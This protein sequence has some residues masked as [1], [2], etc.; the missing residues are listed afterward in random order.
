MILRLFIILLLLFRLFV[1][2]LVLFL[3]LLLL[4][5]ILF[6]LFLLLLLLLLL[7]LF[8]LSSFSSTLYF[9]FFSHYSTT[10]N[11]CLYFSI[12][13]N[14]CFTFSNTFFQALKNIEF[15]MQNH[16]LWNH[17]RL[18]IDVSCKK[19]RKCRFH[20]SRVVKT[21][22]LCHLCLLATIH[23]LQRG[24]PRVRHRAIWCVWAGNFYSWRVGV[25]AEGDKTRERSGQWWFVEVFTNAINTAVVR[26]TP[27]KSLCC[28]RC[29][30][31]SRIDKIWCESYAR[32]R[33]AKISCA[34]I[35]LKRKPQSRH[36]WQ[37]YIQQL[38]AK[39]RLQERCVFL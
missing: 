24:K 10:C 31:N 13:F 11:T 27:P 30:Y 28:G 3:F 33:D 35:D 34:K 26:E 5:S 7:L 37:K 29:V 23:D 2:L 18:N 20:I 22:I 4:L 9:S 17:H 19:L 1:L 39:H 15:F 36:I 14:N 8:L 16:F 32:K 12:F 6:L 25:G 21:D 38:E